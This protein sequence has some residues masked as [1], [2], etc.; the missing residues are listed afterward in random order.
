MLFTDE[1]GGGGQP[2]CRE[3]DPMFW[4]ADAIFTLSKGKL[5]L[6]SY[7]KMPAPHDGIRKLRG[8]ITD[9]WSPFLD[10]TFWFSHGTRAASRW[11]ISPMPL[12]PSRSPTSIV[13][14]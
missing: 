14:R 10:A 1:W 7:Y 6:A 5:T 11:W 9:R 2:R 3:T 12:I 4:G 8:P 13:A